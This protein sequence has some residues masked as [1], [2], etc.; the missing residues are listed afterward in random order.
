[1]A[2]IY[3]IE[4]YGITNSIGMSFGKLWETEMDREAWRAT[5]HWVTKSQ[6]QLKN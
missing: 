2:E 3:A 5:V 1:M 4:L 6:R